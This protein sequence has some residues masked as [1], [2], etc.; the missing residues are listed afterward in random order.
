MAKYDPF[1]CC[2]FC[3]APKRQPGCHDKCP[4]FA[5]AKI[6]FE[7][8]KAVIEADRE[9]RE[10][11]KMAIVKNQDAAAKKRAKWRSRR[12]DYN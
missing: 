5:E 10:Y 4:D 3:V 7:A 12:N 2:H 6:K 9:A 8:R 1:E 11:T